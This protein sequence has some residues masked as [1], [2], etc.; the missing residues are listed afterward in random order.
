MQA[1]DEPRRL[2][3]L[4]PIGVRHIS[5]LPLACQSAIVSAYF[6]IRCDLLFLDPRID[7]LKPLLQWLDRPHTCS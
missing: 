1:M 7:L 4:A 5:T 6:L 2:E 3:S